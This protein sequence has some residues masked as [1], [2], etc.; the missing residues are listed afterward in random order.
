M[1]KNR[2]DGFWESEGEFGEEEGGSFDKKKYKR[3]KCHSKM[4]ICRKF[5]PNR[6]EG[7]CSKIRGMV[8]G[9]GGD[10]GKGGGISKCKRHK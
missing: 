10:S 6:T 4:N 1:F 2:Q 9:N 3:H 5:H 7:K 8:L